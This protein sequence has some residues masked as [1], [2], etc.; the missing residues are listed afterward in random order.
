MKYVSTRGD[1]P[2]LD[3]GDALLTGL[4]VDG[5]LYV[6]DS[7]PPFD[8]EQLAAWRGRPYAE[9][10]TGV[11]ADLVAPALSVDELGPMVEAAYATFD[12]DDV[13]PLRQLGEECHLLEL[14]H[15]PTLSFK[16][17]AL[18][19]VGRLFEHELARTGRTI[20]IVGATSGDTGS[21]AIEAM[22]D[23]DGVQ[24]VMLH[25]AGRV[26]EVQ[27][28]QMTTVEAPNIHNVAVEGTFDD[29]QDIVKALFADRSL[30]DDVGLAAVNSINI[31]RVAA[32]SVYYVTAALALG[33]PDRRVAFTVPTGNF[34]NV[35]AGHLARR[36]GLAVEPFTVATN[37]NDILARFL[38]DGEMRIDH[39][40]PSL[41]PAMDIQVS[42]NFERLL[43]EALDRDGA[44]VAEAIGELRSGGVLPVG[45]E[46][47][48]RIRA[49]FRGDRSSDEQTTA[50]IARVHDEHDVLID[51]HTAVGVGVAA[52]TP[53][54]ADVMKVV[55]ACAHPAKF[56]DTVM[57]ATGHRPELPERLADLPDRPER[58][59]TVPDDVDV[60]R[61]LVREHAR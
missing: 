4:A 17:V 44:A 57:D 32:Q 56:G 55:L 59:V 36:R 38:L 24:L 6:P 9:V 14:F 15:G 12:H 58:F 13:V 29:C 25:P 27:R 53:T 42:S 7:L 45:S 37:R 46:V 1:A 47:V 28:L 43:W 48:E 39:V 49:G 51:P 21:A 26:S 19:L 2:A 60:V 40:E 54:E 31:A 16:D 34:G 10:A 50:T 23:R 41:S 61:D 3:F 8:P 35:Y 11:L 5:G 30:R 18:Q 33:A 22:R 20:T 52:R